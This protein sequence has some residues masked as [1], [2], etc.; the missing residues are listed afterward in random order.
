MLRRHPLPSIRVMRKRL[1]VLALGA[2][3]VPASIVAGCGGVPGNAVAEVDGTPIEKTSFDHWLT[4]ASRS[5]GQAAAAAPKAPNY[6]A[7]I[8]QKRKTTP[9]PAKGQPKVTD[10]QLKKQCKQEY[11]ALRDQ[12]L[13]LLISFKWIEG[14]AKKMG[15]KVTD[16]EVKKSF[17]NQRKQA[18]PKDADFQK[19]LKDSGQT[20]GD[21][22]KRVRLDA[23]SNKIREKVTK[24]KDK[25]TDA[26][27]AAY[28][29]KNKQRFAQPERRDLRIV[30]T[31]NKAKAA[32][33]RKAIAGGQ[34]FASVAKKYSI[35]QT[36]KAQGGKLQAVAKGQQEKALDTAIF[37]AP[38]GKLVGPV[39]TQ[40]GYYVFEVSNISKASQQ[41]L[42]QAKGTIK[43]TLA[44]Q[45]QQK[46]LDN[47]VKSFRKR[48]KAKTDCREGYRTQD[49]KNAP[50]A[51]PTPTPPAGGAQP[52]GQP[53]PGQPAPTPT[54]QGRWATPGTPRRRSSASTR[55]PAAC[56]R[57]APGTASRTSARSSRTRSRRPTSSPPPPTRAT[58]ASC[59]TSSATSSSRSTSSRCCSRS[60]ARARWPRWPSAAARS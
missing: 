54:Q 37:K 46:A 29:N 32:Q 22:L 13:Q 41:T 45:N 26:Q 1:L 19:F 20:E 53:T 59:S 44:S 21:I 60:A 56:A 12:V 4:V 10:A 43:Q 42:N 9:K 5:G 47:F 14:D 31:K 38:K 39:K 24:G 23:L 55:S 7:C 57:S 16:A 8:N 40:F 6:T 52:P 30:L 33:A 28:Y 34:S 36:S 50:K 18:F 27:I 15:V 17:D 48:W 35:D 2:F 51:T 58:T 11:D 25:V 3:F 49:C